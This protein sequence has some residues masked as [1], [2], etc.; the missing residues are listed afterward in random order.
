MEDLAAAEEE[1]GQF[2][3]NGHIHM[4]LHLYQDRLGE[5]RRIG[6]QL[7]E[8]RVGL[9]LTERLVQAGGIVLEGMYSVRPWYD[10]ALY[11]LALGNLELA[12]RQ[13]RL[14]D[15]DLDQEREEVTALL[16]AAKS[17]NA[18]DDWPE[19]YENLSSKRP[20]LSAPGRMSTA[21]IDFLYRPAV[22][23]SLSDVMLAEG[24]LVEAESYAQHA[25]DAIPVAARPNS[26]PAET[27]ASPHG[28]RA[29]ARFLLGN[30]DEAW[31]DLEE[32]DR[33]SSVP[34]HFGG[35]QRVYRL[36]LLIR[37]G[38]LGMAAH[39]LGLT[40][41]A[42]VREE[43]PLL[44]AG[45]S[46]CQADIHLAKSEAEEAQPILEKVLEWAEYTGHQE[47]CLRATLATARIRMQ[48]RAAPEA[49]RGLEVVYRVTR[50]KGFAILQIECLI[51]KAH[52]CLQLENCIGAEEAS[53]E[54]IS[55][56][57]G[58]VTGY[59]WGTASA[60]H[61]IADIRFRQGRTE[62]AQTFAQRACS[63]RASL[64]DAR[65][66][67]SQALLDKIGAG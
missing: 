63:M 4:A 43:C 38:K 45:Y 27:G 51:L 13:L 25:I 29:A 55:L 5:Y 39:L 46:L 9:Q 58:H 28:R 35:M 23:A 20:A 8:Y 22:Y 15:A 26:I 53:Q 47:T 41:W 3:K 30:V 14:L 17:A 42:A 49:G 34:G 18:D 57:E 6:W 24:R 67:N 19:R 32:A 21:T 40:D 52:Q 11:H 48:Q 54:A 33:S 65:L 61:L 7:A 56:C 12:E 10:R 1:I 60:S 50:D 31:S 64:G 2:V 37:Q 62:E 66:W 44:W 16:R 36:Q 59:A